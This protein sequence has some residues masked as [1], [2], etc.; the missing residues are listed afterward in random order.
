MACEFY[1]NFEI[2]IAIVKMYI[3]EISLKIKCKLYFI[4][5]LRILRQ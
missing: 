2:C 4:K 3:L 1:A 5:L